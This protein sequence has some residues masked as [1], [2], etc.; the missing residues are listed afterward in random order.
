MVLDSSAQVP[1]TTVSHSRAAFSIPTQSIGRR[2]HDPAARDMV[3]S[4]DGLVQLR[5][6]FAGR[7]E[8]DSKARHT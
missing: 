2:R 1:A 7:W 3:P 4:R 6:K 5:P 8:S